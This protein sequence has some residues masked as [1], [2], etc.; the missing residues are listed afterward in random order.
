MKDIVITAGRRKR[1]CRWLCAAMVAAFVLNV[2]SI[3]AFHTE[4]KEL[5]TQL[6]WVIC[7]GAGLYVLS[8]VLRWTGCGAVR[9]LRRLLR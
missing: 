7:I 3:A 6:P 4:W 9:L 1:E 8:A 5:W 2:C